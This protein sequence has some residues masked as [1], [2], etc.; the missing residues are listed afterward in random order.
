VSSLI[1]SPRVD[2]KDLDGLRLVSRN[3]RSSGWALL[4]LAV[5]SAQIVSSG[6]VRSDSSIVT[7]RK[8]KLALQ[9]ESR[10][11]LFTSFQ[12]VTVS[13]ALAVS[14]VRFRGLLC[15]SSLYSYNS[16]GTIWTTG[17]V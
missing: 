14:V 10:T 9:L 7:M 6:I 17:R 15:L 1:P 12:S 8:R 2:P 5:L 13:H 3:V 16:T 11:D 4:I